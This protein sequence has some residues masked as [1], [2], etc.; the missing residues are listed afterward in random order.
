MRRPLLFSTYLRQQSTMTDM[1][2]TS[3]RGR[4]FGRAK[5]KALRK[6]QI[7][8]FE[9]VLPKLRVSLGSGFVDPAT[10]FPNGAQEY[11]IEIGFGGGEHLLHRAAENPAIGY[12]GCEPFINGM[13]KMLRD[14]PERGIT[15]I[16]LH[17]RDATE[18]LMALKPAC[19]AAID[20]LYPDP[21]PK[22]RQRKRR[23]ISDECITLMAK[24][25][26]PGGILRFASDI[27]DYI[28]WTLVRMLR[29]G[30]FRWLAESAEDWQKPYTTW[31]GTRYEAKAIREGRVP[32]YLRFER[33]G[34]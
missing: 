8:N 2:K 33:I 24:A 3:Q 9:T 14:I 1:H 10:L 32:S 27:D 7:A 20:I 21:W 13:A 18:L 5:G 34:R 28:G 12:I 22:R 30:E 19:I 23:F 16:R 31:P 17:D 29:S 25:I 15:N 11:R 6:G 26:K 4:F